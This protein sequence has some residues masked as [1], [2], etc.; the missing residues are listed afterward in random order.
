[1]KRFYAILFFACS[2]SCLAQ[3]PPTEFQKGMVLHAELLHGFTRYNGFPEYYL[4]DLRLSPQ[5][6]IAPGILRA[7]ITG[8][9]LYT[10]TN[11]SLFA[12][13]NLAVN[14]KTIGAGQLGSLANLQLVL[15]HL[16]GSDKQRLVG[17]GI[18]AEIGKKLLLSVLSHRD[19]QLKYWNLQFGVGINLLR[20]RSNNG[21][22]VN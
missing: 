8:G 13:P 14:I 3:Q 5:W 10:Q 18:R 6:T 22:I 2:F 9:L 7:G 16:W 12:G 4:A 15:E 1:M 11:L 19:Y 20:K 21:N 17:G